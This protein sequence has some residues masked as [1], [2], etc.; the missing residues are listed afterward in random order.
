MPTE[1]LQ[2]SDI[3]V[4]MT[5]FIRLFNKKSYLCIVNLGTINPLTF[6]DSTKYQWVTMFCRQSNIDELPS[7]YIDTLYVSFPTF[8]IYMLLLGTEIFFVSVLI[9]SESTCEPLIV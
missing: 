9:E 6:G 3:Y 1:Y 2:L 7:I 8:I 5:L 4:N